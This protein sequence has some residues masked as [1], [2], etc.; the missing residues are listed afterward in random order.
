ML[1]RNEKRTSIWALLCGLLIWYC[2]TFFFYFFG[3]RICIH[4]IWK[5][6]GILKTPMMRKEMPKWYFEALPFNKQSQPWSTVPRGTWTLSQ[7]S[8]AA[9]L[10]PQSQIDHK[11]VPHGRVIVPHGT[12]LCHTALSGFSSTF[13]GFL[14][15]NSCKCSGSLRVQRARP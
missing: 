9:L 10:Q 7:E 3:G 2:Y 11:T 15:K 14:T 12:H 1:L 5:S 8:R 6:S 13:M 4:P